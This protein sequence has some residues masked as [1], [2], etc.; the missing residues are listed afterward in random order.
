MSKLHRTYLDEVAPQPVSPNV[1]EFD[2]Q[3]DNADLPDELKSYLKNQPLKDRWEYLTRGKKKTQESPAVMVDKLYNTPSSAAISACRLWITQ[4]DSF[5][6]SEFVNLG[7]LEELIEILAVTEDCRTDDDSLKQREIVKLVCE[8]LK[9]DEALEFLVTNET[10]LSTIILTLRPSDMALNRGVIKILEACCWVNGNSYE[11]VLSALDL[12][13]LE[14]NLDNCFMMLGELL[15]VNRASLQ[16]E[17]MQLVIGLLEVIQD[18]DI[19]ASVKNTL[20][21]SNFIAISRELMGLL[22]PFNAEEL[23]QLEAKLKARKHKIKL[24]EEAVRTRRSIIRRPS[25]KLTFDPDAVEL[26]RNRSKNIPVSKKMVPP[27]LQRGYSRE[28]KSIEEEPEQHD[29]ALLM[30]LSAMFAHFESIVTGVKSLTLISLFVKLLGQDVSNSLEKVLKSLLD[31]TAET[32]DRKY[33]WETVTDLLLDLNSSEPSSDAGSL[34]GMKLFELKQSLLSLQEELEAQHA[35]RQNIQVE[36]EKIKESAAEREGLL[37]R[38][39]EALEGDIETLVSDNFNLVEKYEDLKKASPADLVLLNETIHELRASVSKL[40]SDLEKAKALQS[41]NTNQGNFAPQGTVLPPVTTMPPLPGTGLPPPLPGSGPPPPLP[42][43]SLP[44]PLPGLGM[45]PPLPNSSLPPPLPGTQMPPPLP[46]TGLPPPLPGAGLPPPLPGLGMAPPLPGQQMS[47][48]PV[49]RPPPKAKV[50]PDVPMKK[51]FWDPVKPELVLKT[52]WSQVNDTKV[53]LD[54]SALIAV[55]AEKQARPVTVA[56]SSIREETEIV[57]KKR[58]QLIEIMLARLKHS[59]ASITEALFTFDEDL[60]TP[61]VVESLKDIL[62]SDSELK[63]VSEYEASPHLLGLTERFFVALSRVP[64]F[65][66]RVQSI[67]IK[68]HAEANFDSLKKKISRL[69]QAHTEVLNSTKLKTLLEVVLAFG[70]YMNGISTRGGAYGFSIAFLTK[71]KDTRGEGG[72]NLL[73]FIVRFLKSKHSEALQLADDLQNL[74]EAVKVSTKELQGDLAVYQGQLK[75]LKSA[76]GSQSDNPID[77]AEQRLS[78][79]ISWYTSQLAEAGQG[80][81]EAER[82]YNE[83]CTY[84]AIDPSNEETQDVLGLLNAFLIDYGKEINRLGIKK[85]LK[86]AELLVRITMKRNEAR[87]SSLR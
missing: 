53:E 23:R 54:V 26:N 24:S 85:P 10:A 31:L 47:D 49:N 15:K 3:L 63:L 68:H 38:R 84:L 65:A 73:E 32:S 6:V 60:L 4:A 80:L 87:L 16:A 76:M 28:K 35:S 59:V 48:Q 71:L 17:V 75:V 67:H 11:H 82:T 44:P 1:T 40:T 2:R 79:Y 12:Y 14:R 86:A 43:T 56:L 78:G 22:E 72:V 9:C 58:C 18:D 64:K 41:A 25:K 8:L 5:S 27:E 45:P 30:Q 50:M 66:Q 21:S 42:G 36:L 19:Y 61:T 37:K 69:V 55:F 62:P 29:P 13:C 74:K 46:G 52:V 83:M 34:S 77:K 51:V 81:G 39:V 57:P 20:E 70:N 7:G 33:H